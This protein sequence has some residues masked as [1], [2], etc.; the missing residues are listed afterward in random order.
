MNRHLSRAA[1]GQ[2]GR[3]R[4]LLLAAVASLAL[5]SIS[6][7][8]AWAQRDY[9]AEGRTLLQ[10]GDL[11]AAQIALRNAVRDDPRNAEAQYQLA[12]V[13]LALGDVSSAEKAARQARELGYPARDAVALLTETYLAQGRFRQLLEEVKPD[14]KD[15][16]ADAELLAAYAQAQT[17]LR[18]LDAARSLL[19]EAEKTAPNSAPGLLAA[20]RLALAARDP[21]EAER[22]VDRALAADPN[23][24]A[25]QVQKALLLRQRNDNA[26]AIALFDRIVAQHPDR[27]G[28]RLERAQAYISNGEDAKAKADVDAILTATPNNAAALYA[29]GVLQARARDFAAADATLQRIAAVLPNMPRGLYL[30]ALVKQQIGQLEQAIDSAQ[31][32]VSRA[33]ND[34]TGVKLLARLHMQN[35]RPD[36]AVTAL[37]RLSEANVVDAELYDLL[38]Q[39][40]VA[41]GQHALAVPAFQRATTL[42][43]EDTNIR[44]RL[45]A[46][47][48]GSGAPEAAA[49]DLSRSLELAPTAAG[50][51]EALFFTELATGDLSRAA[52]AVERVRKAQ[53]DVPLVH[54][55]EGVLKMAQR[56]FVGARA[57]FHAALAKQADF[58]PAQVNLARL[59]LQLNRLADAERLL[60]A[61]LNRQPDADPALS[62][63]TGILLRR[64]ALNDAIAL[65]RKAVEASPQA[66][67]PRLLLAELYTRAKE[68]KKAVEALTMPAGTPA[69]LELQIA[70]GRAQA[71]AG[72]AAD[73]R[74]A[75]AKALE[76]NPRAVDARR[77]LVALLV[78]AGEI[79]RAR[80]TI[81]AGLR[82]DPK[83]YPL[84]AEF[85]GVDLRAGGID[86][87]LSTA[88]RLRRQ[89]PADFSDAAALRGDAFMMARRAD[90]ALAAYT[91][92]RKTAPTSFLTMRLAAAMVNNNR[93]DDAIALLRDWMKAHPGD[94]EAGHLLSGLE[95]GRKQWT[96]AE[97]T[98][99]KILETDPR[100]GIAL[101]NLAWVMQMR[102][103]RR[104]RELAEKAYLLMPTPQ[105]A[106]TLGWILLS[107]GALESSMVLL[108][109]AATDL[110]GDP[111]IQYHYA[112][113]LH[114]AGQNAEAVKILRGVVEHAAT[115]DEKAEAQK[116][117]DQLKGS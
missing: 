24:L 84:M 73:A 25:A 18:N 62:M 12:R 99:A 102:G 94:R 107:E 56:D 9:L 66:T 45:A 47:R 95:I 108:R 104:A 82:V 40:H 72:N 115:F 42:A 105:T 76:A 75:L 16:V 7:A 109:Q 74:D 35:R 80:S 117:L 50:V 14:G 87:A 27:L 100:N 43:P 28:L 17:G 112:V 4:P 116:L 30:H 52:A 88:D 110:P 2:T 54:N 21:A 64:D 83:S 98:L 91:E 65:V 11:R 36:L 51:G 5:A 23:Y 57:A 67:R 70:L 6:P 49:G 61:V 46:A 10:K 111:R 81:E 19:A 55:I 39:A 59:D 71:L 41:A 114:R 60:T 101:N 106:D 33:P 20:A 79:E 85:V 86:L 8:P 90:D 63:M 103:D 32:H 37:K 96:E 26:A 53:G 92:A 93:T 22:R 48:L 77:Q 13:F 58:I 89:A 78:A 69:P 68:P 97:A 1:A 3:L 15:P 34:I 38:G 31:K 44:T 113:A 29:R